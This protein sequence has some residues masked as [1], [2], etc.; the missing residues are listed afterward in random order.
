MASRPS[1]SL[2]WITRVPAAVQRGG[3]PTAP[4]NEKEGTHMAVLERSELEASP[5]ADLHAIADQLGLDGFRR[6]RKAELIDAILVD[7]RARGRKTP[8]VG[9]RLTRTA[10]EGESGRAETARGRRRSTRT[11]TGRT[12]ALETR[13]EGG[14][15]VEPSAPAG[16]E[17]RRPRAPPPQRGRERRGRRGAAGQRLGL[18]ARR[19]ARA[20]RRGR[21]HLRG[22]GSPLRAGLGRPGERTGAHAPSLR[23]LPVAR[24]E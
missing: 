10:E 20:F 12:A 13:L 15:V 24:R 19:P 4:S 23:A 11:A 9:R 21:L 5:L 6:L 2:G 18:S 14:A 8:R 17:R 22:A 16:D 3:T 1:R 7:A